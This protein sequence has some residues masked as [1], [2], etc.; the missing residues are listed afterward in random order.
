[1]TLASPLFFDSPN[2]PAPSPGA[3]GERARRPLYVPDPDPAPRRNP[4]A[5]PGFP[6]NPPKPL[7]FGKRK[8]SLEF[9]GKMVYH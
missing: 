5:R 6:E 9:P 2:P 8:K 4:F 3:L 1:M 7:G